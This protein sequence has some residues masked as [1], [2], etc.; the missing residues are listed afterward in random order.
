M[1]PTSMRLFGVLAA[2]TGRILWICVVLGS[3][4]IHFGHTLFEYQ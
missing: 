1:I 4:W 2:N 3:F